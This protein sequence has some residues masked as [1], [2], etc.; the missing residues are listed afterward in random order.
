MEVAIAVV[1]LVGLGIA[2]YLIFRRARAAKP[3]G[4]QFVCRQCG[5]NHCEGESKP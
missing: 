3:A 1:A 4:T 2:G 5:E